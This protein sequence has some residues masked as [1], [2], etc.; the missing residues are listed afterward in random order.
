LP[1]AVEVVIIQRLQECDD[2]V[3]FVYR[4]N[5]LI[6]GMSSRCTTKIYTV[7]VPRPAPSPVRARIGSNFPLPGQPR[8][9]RT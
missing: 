8:P 6:T 3:N 5:L 4:Q 1:L 2:V 7:P 9:R